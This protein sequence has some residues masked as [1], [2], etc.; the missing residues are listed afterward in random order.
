MVLIKQDQKR[1]V[2]GLFELFT[3]KPK[4]N[5]KFWEGKHEIHHLRTWGD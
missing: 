4:E 1:R 5:D 2:S 3:T